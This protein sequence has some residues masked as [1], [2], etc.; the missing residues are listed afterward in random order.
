MLTVQA[1]VKGVEAA[2]KLPWRVSIVGFMANPRVLQG[3]PEAV[4]ETFRALTSDSYF[5]II[6]VQPLPEEAWS[7]AKSI[8]DQRGVEIALGLQPYVLTRGVNPSALN[9]DVRR[10]S[11]ATILEE[12]R[13]ARERGVTKVAFCSGPDPGPADRGAAMDALVK[14][15]KEVSAAAQKLGVTVILETFDRDWDRKQLI[16]PIAEA[17]KVAEQ[18]REEYGNF[19]L[20][21]D[22]SHG[23]LLNE[24]PSVLKA[25][26]DYLV[27]VHIGCA[28][29]LPD[30]RLVDWHPGFYRPGAVNGVEE[31]K[32]LLRVLL[33]LGYR[34]TIG[35]E[36]KPE[37][38][39]HWLE[40]VMSAKG[41]LY[42][43]FSQLAESW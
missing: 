43:A 21:W 25:A 9:E 32:E 20:L 29:R 40:P 33:E 7:I 12:V 26:K 37:E 8:A 24:S 30:G 5:D 4:R 27:H 18:V 42:T 16:G 3:D 2:V 36:V 13:K 19:G 38:G 11:V 22:L 31:V 17:V 6:E 15:L 39:Q 1:R 34:G 41:V 23:P 14:S 10:K 28:K 35:F